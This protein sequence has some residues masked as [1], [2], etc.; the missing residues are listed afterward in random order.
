MRRTEEEAE[1]TRQRLLKAALVVFSRQGYADTH[2]EDIAE[3]AEVTRGA[4]YHHFGGKAKLYNEIV[5]E[6]TKRVFPV[7]KAALDEGG[8]PLEKLSRIFVRTLVYVEEDTDFRAIQELVLF[9]TAITPELAVGIEKKIEGTR[10]TIDFLAQTFQQGIDVGEV[11]PNIEPHDA[12]LSFTALQNGLL[13]LWLFDASMFS[14]K[15]QAERQAD[16]LMQ[17]LASR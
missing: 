3:E 4:I 17:G 11:R 12:A 7:I 6:G 1:I 9:K 15:E 2:L 10:G 13:T 14:L 8:T 16:I 5:A